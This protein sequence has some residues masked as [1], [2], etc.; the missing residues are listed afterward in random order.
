MANAAC[1]TKNEV[2]TD[3]FGDFDGPVQVG[4]DLRAAA[5]AGQ[6][7]HVEVVVRKRIHAD[8]I[9]KQGATGSLSGRVNAEQAHLLSGV[10]PL[11]AKHQFIEETGFSST[12][13]SGE[14]DDRDILVR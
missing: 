4:A 10:V 14:P 13:R 11:N 9:P 3:R 1:F 7:A 5:T 12:A 2:E 6:A 8:A